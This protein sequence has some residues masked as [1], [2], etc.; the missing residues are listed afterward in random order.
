[1]MCKSGGFNLTKF[2]CNSK[3]VLD[4]IPACDR[5]KSVAEFNLM[6]QQ[7]PTEAVLGVLWNVDQDV[8]TFKVKLKDKAMSKRGMLST[9]SSIYDPLG[10]VTSFILQGRKILQKLCEE[11]INWDDEVNQ[12]FKDSWENWKHCIKQLESVKINRCFMNCNYQKIT[13]CSLHHFTDASESGYDVV[14]YIRTVNEEGKI[15]CQKKA[16]ER[17]YLM[18]QY[19]RKLKK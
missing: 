16:E 7:L 1:M 8:F 6:N 14:T 18:L 17:V 2:L 5:R 15:Y 12:K 11:K 10:F 3:V 9:L 19:Y 13:H 4:T